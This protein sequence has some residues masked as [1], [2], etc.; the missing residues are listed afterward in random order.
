MKGRETNEEGRL[1]GSGRA[2]GNQHTG[3]QMKGRETNEEGG[4]GGS[5]RDF[6]K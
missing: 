4:L 3:R 5:G 2:F 6:G 1:G